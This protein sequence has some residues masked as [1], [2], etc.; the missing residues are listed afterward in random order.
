M[1][2][3]EKEHEIFLCVT[4]EDLH[5]VISKFYSVGVFFRYGLQVYC[6]GYSS[7]PTSL[8]ASGSL[9]HSYPPTVLISNGGAS[10]QLHITLWLDKQTKVQ[11]LILAV[12]LMSDTACGFLLFSK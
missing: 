3:C 6:V 12:Y 7:P 9:K 4:P 11:I 10:D 2:D 5:V 8:K 1:Q